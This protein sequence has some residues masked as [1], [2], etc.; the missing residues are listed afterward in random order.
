MRR[1]G[2]GVTFATDEDEEEPLAE[3][4]TREEERRRA[5]RGQEVT[6]SSCCCP[7]LLPGGAGDHSARRQRR[8]DRRLVL[9]LRKAGL[10]WSRFAARS[11]WVPVFVRVLANACIFYEFWAIPVWLAF[12]PQ[13]HLAPALL[14][15][16]QVDYL[17]NTLLLL[18]QLLDV[19]EEAGKSDAAQG[20]LRRGRR[21]RG[22]MS[23]SNPDGSRMASDSAK[24]A[25]STLAKDEGT[26]S[27][28]L[29]SLKLNF[30]QSRFLSHPVYRQSVVSDTS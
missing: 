4:A 10:L 29:H 7:C 21:R 20:S 22:E 30:F 3:K 19:L 27:S 5:E 11:E 9:L 16:A 23:S 28:S 14:A 17:A 15:V 6:A 1:A 8:R 2:L 26:F 13:P 24:S 12:L 25:T 18:T